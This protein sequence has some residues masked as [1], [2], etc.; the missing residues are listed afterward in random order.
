MFS[1]AKYRD[2]I[3]NERIAGNPLG[4]KILAALLKEGVL[5]SDPKFYYVEA[6]Q[7]DEKLGISWHQLRQYKSSSKLEAFL[8]RV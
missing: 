7:C 1:L 2:K 5:R 4:K 3:E 6:N 8:K